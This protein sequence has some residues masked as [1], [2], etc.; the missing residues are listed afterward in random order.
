MYIRRAKIISVIIFV[1][2]YRG[3]IMLYVVAGQLYNIQP[4]SD[5]N[6]WIFVIY[7]FTLEGFLK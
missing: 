3:N 4:P 7:N 6:K 1:Y 5:H 2:C